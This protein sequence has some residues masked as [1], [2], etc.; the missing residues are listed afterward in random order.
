MAYFHHF[1]RDILLF[2]CLLFKS[3]C[4]VGFA[5][6]RTVNMSSTAGRERGGINSNSGV[7]F[8]TLELQVVAL[9]HHFRLEYSRLT[10][11]SY[12]DVFPDSW[13]RI[14]PCITG[15]TRA[16]NFWSCD[17]ATGFLAVTFFLHYLESLRKLA[18]VGQIVF[19]VN[20]GVFRRW[21]ADLEI[22]WDLWDLT[23]SR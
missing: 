23:V 3:R 7:I 15:K 5:L 22:N 13:A 4:K 6:I 9:T 18:W 19:T 11:V 17:H 14:S 2:T 10:L 12:F 16:E 20:S 1:F 21:W 8:R